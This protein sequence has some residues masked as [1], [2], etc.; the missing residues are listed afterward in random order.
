MSFLSRRRR[1]RHKYFAFIF[2]IGI[3]FCFN[4]AQRFVSLQTV[5]SLYGSRNSFGQ[6]QKYFRPPEKESGYPLCSVFLLYIFSYPS[7]QVGSTGL[8][9]WK[10]FGIGIC[11][12]AASLLRNQTILC[13]F[14]TYLYFRFGQLLYSI[15][16]CRSRSFLLFVVVFFVLVSE[17]FISLDP[18]DPIEYKN[19]VIQT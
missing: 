11:P 12:V 17:I 10:Y 18:S 13:I 4:L 9:L 2:A 1:R 19:S 6:R 15:P 16:M 8:Y 7:I 3:A 14:L 5:R